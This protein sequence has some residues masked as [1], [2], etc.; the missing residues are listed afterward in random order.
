MLPF[1]RLLLIPRRIQNNVVADHVFSV[2]GP[3]S[4][5]HCCLPSSLVN[6]DRVVTEINKIGRIAPCCAA[7]ITMSPV[8]D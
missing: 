5:R 1:D 3:V 7:G 8:S 6:R 4:L 2:T